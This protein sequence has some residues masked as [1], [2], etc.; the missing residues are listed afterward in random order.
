MPIHNSRTSRRPTCAAVLLLSLSFLFAPIAARAQPSPFARTSAL[1][2]GAG[3]L[4]EPPIAASLDRLAQA[5]DDTLA[6]DSLAAPVAPVPPPETPSSAR[7]A[8]R[9]R[10]GGKSDDDLALRGHG[11]PDP[12]K[13]IVENAKNFVSDALYLYT[14]PLRMD[15]KNLAWVAGVSAVGVGL[16]QYDGDIFDGAVRS[17]DDPVFHGVVQKAGGFFEPLG[18]ISKTHWYYSGASLAG[19]VFDVPLLRTIPGEILESNSIVGPLRQPIEKIVGR[20]RPSESRN[21]RD[22]SGGRSFPSGHASVICETAAILS[23][24]ATYPAARIVIWSIAGLVCVER[25]DPERVLDHWPSDI[26]MG[27]ALGTWAGHT[28]AVRNEERR[29]GIPQRKWYDVIH[30]P[31][32]AD[33]SVMP[34]TSSEGVPGLAVKTSF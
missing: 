8:D 11:R 31:P 32:K 28:I 12:I 10:E 2:P 13:S 4:V 14:A 25:I 18:L 30:R 29:H 5:S 27:A 6:T 23:H 33:W 34:Y 7:P 9:D 20:R 26:W 3:F 1:E 21:P 15:G 24:H 22:F 16:Y 19:W 17:V